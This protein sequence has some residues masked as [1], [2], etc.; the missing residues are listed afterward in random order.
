MANK[1]IFVTGHRN[2]DSDSICSAIAYADLKQRLGEPAIAVRQGPLNEETKY[3]L[4]RFNVENP[5]VLNDARSQIRDIDF[6]EPTLVSMDLTMSEAWD[7]LSAKNV[8]SL[9]VVDEMKKLQG[10]VST[11]NLSSTRNMEYEKLNSLMAK[12]S[13]TQIA[14]TIKGKIICEPENF[15]SDGEVYIFTLTN[16]KEYSEKF[17]NSIVILSD[18]EE[19][20]R[21]LI[22]CG[23]ALIVVTCKVRVSEENR[24][25]AIEKGVALLRTDLDTMQVARVI[26]E[27]IPIRY[28][29]TPQPV[30][31]FDDEV[32]SE[33]AQRLSQT[34]YRCYP[35]VNRRGTVVGS[36]S[37]YHFAN[38]ARRRF[39]LVDHSAKNQSMPH[40]DDARIEEIVDHHHIG[41]IQTSHP[42]TYR[43]MV[44]G[45]S[46]SI[47]GLLYQE[48][49][50]K[51]TQEMAGLM[52]GAIISD[53]M[54]FKSKTTTNFDKKMAEWLA[55]IAGVELKEFALGVLGASVSLKT[56]TPNE[57][58]NRDL[59][60]YQIG[61]YKIGIGQTN[62]EHME[63]VQA[64]LPNFK[65]Y[66]V[67]IQEEQ[68]YDLLVMMFSNIMAEGSLFVYSGKLKGI[69]EDIVDTVIDDMTGF[70]NLIISRKQQ[71]M[72]KVSEIIK[73]L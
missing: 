33:V 58:L 72:P 7:K 49:D 18:D 19:K 22:D 34:R 16:M 48:Q 50:L 12:A 29:M 4:K 11:S 54:Y 61:K 5:F 41:D 53:T 27:A 73:M 35:V 42:I 68:G 65:E 57:I 28:V 26:N 40:I 10:I 45:C 37:R 59:K 9:F 51:P 23:A 55:D 43:N 71:M 69:M 6:D 36:V 32:V 24:L 1:T 39:I 46:A 70:D 47:V 56:A 66:L 44:C 25:Y 21:Q 63:E 30:T 31:C 52:L 2:P 13:V 3:I 62:Y 8:K 14:K 64:L 60:N 20:Q 17:R 38:Y 67:Q 15:N